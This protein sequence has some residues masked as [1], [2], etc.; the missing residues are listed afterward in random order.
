MSGSIQEEKDQCRGWDWN[1][2]GDSI[3]TTGYGFTPNWTVCD[4]SWQAEWKGFI[5]LT[6]SGQHCFMITGGT[7]EGCASLFF[8]TETNG[9]QTAAGAR[10]YNMSAGVY[11]ILWH[12]TM[13]NGSTSSMH[14]M[15]CFGGGSTCTPSATLPASMLRPTYP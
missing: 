8:N 4:S 15:Y 10:C 14:L 1:D 12:Y 2:V 9:V 3:C 13:D 5:N 6:S 7:S 11:P